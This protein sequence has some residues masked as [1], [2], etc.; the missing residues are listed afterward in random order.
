MK[1]TYYWFTVGNAPDDLLSKSGNLFDGVPFTE[2]SGYG[3]IIEEKSSTRIV[4]TFFERKEI[5][6][7]VQDP[8]GN[9]TEHR[10][11]TY[12]SVGFILQK[13]F[14][15]LTLINP[16]RNYTKLIKLIDRSLESSVVFNKV[17]FQDLRVIAKC[18]RER[19]AG[20]RIVAIST[21]GLL[22][23]G[24]T[25]IDVAFKALVDVEADSES[26][27]KG[28]RLHW[29]RIRLQIPKLHGESEISVWASGKVSSDFLPNSPQ[30]RIVCKIIER[31]INT[32][33]R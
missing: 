33:E 26:F 29:S 30:A 7:T 15:H 20:A 1:T 3:F 19:L 21:D 11:I 23:K 2:E 6:D 17:T 22:Y 18:F 13:G 28:Q 12:E 24:R 31:C 4:G 5:I 14:P 27:I 32:G 16:A 8:S 25:L 10:R 9:S